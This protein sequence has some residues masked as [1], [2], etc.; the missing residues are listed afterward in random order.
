[1]N[2]IISDISTMAAWQ[3]SRASALEI[4]Q[5]EM[6][7]LFVEGFAGMKLASPMMLR[8]K[9]VR[10]TND[11]TRHRCRSEY[12]SSSAQALKLHTRIQLFP[13]FSEECSPI[14]LLSKVLL[15][16]GINM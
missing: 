14:Q 16:V 9:N 15:Q 6:D 1:M 12:S 3:Q 13:T 4:S 5:S 7:A 10:W 2:N 11:L 8:E